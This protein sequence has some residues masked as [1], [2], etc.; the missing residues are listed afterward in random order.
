VTSPVT[1]PVGW[2]EASGPQLGTST[3]IRLLEK[4]LESVTYR[5]GSLWAVHNLFTNTTGVASL[6][7]WWQLSTNGTILQRGRLE[8]PA[9]INY[10]GYPS[11][12]V[13]ARN[14]VLI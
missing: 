4:T 7:Q 13:N 12:A 14:D 3:K 10:Y 9:G 8:D 5:N 2:G 11:L 1:W 6:I